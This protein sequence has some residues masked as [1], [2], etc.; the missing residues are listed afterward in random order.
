[1]K[2]TEKDA[3]VKK[4]GAAKAAGA[5]RA[6]IEKLMTDDKIDA[7]GRAEIIA[8]LFAPEKGADEEGQNS[9]PPKQKAKEEAKAKPND[10]LQDELEEINYK[11]LNG[12]NFKKYVEIAGDKNFGEVKDGEVK[13]VRGRLRDIDSYDYDV[14]KAAPILKDRFPGME[15]SPKDYI[16][17]R[18]IND[19]PITSTRINVKT[20]LELNAQIL[21]Q[22]SRSGNG[23][24]YLL[25]KY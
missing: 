14:F 1:M 13:P 15:G 4:Y 16:G 22:H 20:A 2:K 10:E 5:N 19:T 3:A 17:V 18:I 23:R 8:V 21:N 11:E 6:E 9:A 24:Y 12:E 7:P 25:K